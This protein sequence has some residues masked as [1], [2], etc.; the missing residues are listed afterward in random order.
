M[1]THDKHEAKS[2]SGMHYRNLALMAVLSYGAMYWLMYAMVDRFAN[3]Y[4][5]FNQAYMAGLMTAP[6]IVFELVLMRA[7]YSNRRA[8]AAILMG[9]LVLFAGCFLAIRSQ[10]GISDQQFLK[11]M[12][13]HHAGALLMCEQTSLKDPAIRA[14]CDGIKTGQ[15]SEIDF[16]K[17]KLE[18]L[19]K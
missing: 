11:S 5:N 19:N 17:A 14:L 7:M 8:N 12:I 2:M 13:P 3:V 4:P 16:M 1:D 9:S 6:M 10:A 15:Q 18:E